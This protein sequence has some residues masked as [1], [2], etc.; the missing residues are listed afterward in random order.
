MKIKDGFLLRTIAGTHIVVPVEDRVIE[1]KGM[2][3]LNDISAKI[4]GF[5]DVDREYDDIVD[6]VL[7]EYETDSETVKKDLDA[8][9][10]K[11]ENSGVL[12]K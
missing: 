8:L 6:F 11:M 4:W 12:V 10:Q 1:F 7:S 5:M 3:V 9:L 2:M